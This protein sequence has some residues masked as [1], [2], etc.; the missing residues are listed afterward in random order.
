MAGR[1]DRQEA[2]WPLREPLAALVALLE[3]TAG[4]T[5]PAATRA[6]LRQM[7]GH[8]VQLQAAC[9]A[10]GTAFG[11]PGKV[12]ELT[13][14]DRPRPNAEELVGADV[15]RQLGREEGE[16]PSLTARERRI[17]ELIGQGWTNRQIAGELFLAEKT[18]RNYVSNLLRKL[19]MERRTQAAVYAHLDLAGARPDQGRR[20]PA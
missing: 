13:A 14:V 12:V 18:V 7:A 15:L 8:V 20:L 17:L 5:V 10:L 19:G 1:T 3:E 2:L 4:H 6:C 11:T 9:D 16:R